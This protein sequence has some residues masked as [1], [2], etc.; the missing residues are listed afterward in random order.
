MRHSNT[1]RDPR[2]S[3]EPHLDRLFPALKDGPAVV[4]RL[5]GH[6]P[7][8]STI[9]RYIAKGQYGVRL[10]TLFV[11]GTA[12][13]SERWLLEFF[14]AVAEARAMRWAERDQPEIRPAR[15]R[16]RTRR[17]SSR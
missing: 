11:S 16:R 13:T 10:K 6:R 14:A 12:Y 7:H 1:K 4:E 9:W 2:A 8:K 3:R 5:C 17:R 15:L